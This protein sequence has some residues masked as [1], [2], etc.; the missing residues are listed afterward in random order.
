MDV[1]VYERLTGKSVA[2]DKV[3]YFQAQIDRVQSKL[4]NILGYT[5]APQ[6]I[7]SEL[8]KTK[9]EC[10]CPNSP[11][12][13]DLLPP[14]AVQGIV[15]IFPYN[16][17]DQYL[18]VDPFYQVYKVKL[19]RIVGNNQFITLKTFDEF[20]QKMMSGGIG[21]AI[22]KCSGCLCSCECKDCVQ[23]VVDADW[24]DFSD[25]GRSVPNDLLYLLCD[26]VDY[27]TDESR[28]YQSESV[29]GHSWTRGSEN[30]APEKEEDALILLSR[31]TGPFGQVNRIPVL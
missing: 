13:A 20:D 31:F 28:K 6:H 5:L 21:K 26:M 18:M 29:T 2:K 3:Q 24:V 27:Y 22:E 8:G 9:Q 16:W 11:E 12:S 14:D 17:K 1:Q 19:G 15:K 4:E 10:V 30:I 25:K 23:L 7:Y